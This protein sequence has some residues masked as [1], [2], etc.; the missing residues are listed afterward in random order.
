MNLTGALSR[1]STRELTMLA[2]LVL[3]GFMIWLSSLWR[4]W[5]VA[6]K[7]LRKAR[8]ELAQQAAW[9][10]DSDRFAR[11]LGETLSQ[12]DPE[13]T[14]DADE[15]VA[16][17]DGAARDTGMKYELSAVATV[18]QSLFLQHTLRVGIKNTP[19]VRLI[20]FERTLRTNHPYA[21][22]EDFS[23][24]ANKADPRLLNARLTI[25][26]YQLKRDAADE[27]KTDE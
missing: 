10:G 20:D 8:Q 9:L 25:T 27:V 1:I 23:I 22:L 18:E 17:I 3:V 12:L 6:G 4:H 16:L 5:D 7:Q 15:L 13:S 24:T 19:L 21:A 14:L 2:A 26:S 11:E